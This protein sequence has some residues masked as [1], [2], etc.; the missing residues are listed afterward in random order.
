MISLYSSHLSGYE[1]NADTQELLIEFVGGEIYRYDDVPQY[2][3]DGLK[4]ATSAGRYFKSNIK[5][6][7]MFIRE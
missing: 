5:G 3:V 1:Y 7:F 2:I 4:T 6:R